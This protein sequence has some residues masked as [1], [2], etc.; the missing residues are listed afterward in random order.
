MIEQ[1][2]WL[3][4][5]V[6]YLDEARD[7]Y[8]G[9]LG[10]E[11]ETVEEDEVLYPLPDGSSL[12]LRAPGPVPRGGVH[13]HYALSAPADEIDRWR[14]RVEDEGLPTWTHEFGDTTSLYFYDPDGHCVEVAGTGGDEPISGLFEVVLEVEDLDAAVELYTELGAEVYGKGE[15][16]RR[17]LDAGAVDLELWLPRLGLADGQGGVHVDLGF[18]AEGEA[19]IPEDDRLEVEE[20]DV[21]RRFRDPDG[22]YLTYLD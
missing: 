1:L 12:V 9:V 22:H 5:E 16:D 7:F 10:L 17:R 14:E 8:E 4:L 13:T 18:V 15:S 21:G 11:P 3:A 6:K 2:E 19:E 20:V